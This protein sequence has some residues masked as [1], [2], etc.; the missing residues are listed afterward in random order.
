MNDLDNRRFSNMA[1]G[2]VGMDG[3]GSRRIARV[4]VP[5]ALGS[6]SSLLFLV[7]DVLGLAAVYPDRL[8]LVAVTSTTGVV[9]SSNLAF[10]RRALDCA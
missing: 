4:V 2:G 6:A 9:R 8:V 10:G 7:R 5:L 3:K 1:A